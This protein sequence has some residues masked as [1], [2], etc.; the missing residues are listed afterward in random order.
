M[1]LTETCFYSR[2]YGI[3]VTLQEDFLSWP[4]QF[5]FFDLIFFPS[6]LKTSSPCIWGIIYFC[7]TNGF[8][9]ILEKTSS[10]LIFTQLYVTLDKIR[11]NQII[12]IH[13]LI[14]TLAMVQ[15]H[16]VVWLVSIQSC[17]QARMKET[18]QTANKG[19]SM[20]FGECKNLEE[21]DGQ[22]QLLCYV[23]LIRA[24]NKV[25]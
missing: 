17:F 15:K 23:S 12:E 25:L 19:V 4:F 9:R 13:Q 8:F 6:L 2:L 14:K 5:F 1:S 20:Q 10:E 24:C 18:R 7:N 22:T 21:K 16:L 3:F 11:S